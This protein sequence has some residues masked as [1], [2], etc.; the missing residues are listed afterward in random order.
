MEV[1]NYQTSINM[2]KKIRYREFDIHPSAPGVNRGSERLV[3]GSDRSIYYTDD[4]YGTFT[5]LQG[6]S[7]VGQPL[8]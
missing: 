3:V 1:Q 2:A 6:S 7:I 8:W 5:P 4:H